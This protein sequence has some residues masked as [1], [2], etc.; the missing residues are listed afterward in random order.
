MVVLV[1]NAMSVQVERRG[2]GSTGVDVVGRDRLLIFSTL[3]VCT[4]MKIHTRY[5]L[6]PI[7]YLSHTYQPILLAIVKQTL[8]PSQCE[9]NIHSMSISSYV[10]LFDL[11]LV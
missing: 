5:F 9:N 8:L 3:C 7:S 1:W 4:S 6:R 10:R 2:N 11:V